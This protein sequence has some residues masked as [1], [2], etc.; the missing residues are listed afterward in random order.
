[1]PIEERWPRPSVMG[2]VNVTPD[3]FSD[4]GRFV[5]PGAAVA[6]AR[7]LTEEG[8]AI[9]DIGGESTRPGAAPV[10]AEDEL[11]RLGPVLEA[12]SGVS[13]SVDTS[14]AVVARRALELG[15]AMVND[16]T[17]LV[18]DPGM[19]E[20][21][22]EF[23]AYVCLMHM[24]GEPRTMQVAP[25]YDDVVDDVLE[26]LEQR[27]AF[28]V[29]RGIA[30]ERICVDPGFG[31]G[32][33]PDQNLELLRRLDELRSLGR[34]VLVGIS[35]KSTLG[36][37][38]GDRWCD[39]RL[40]VGVAGRCRGRVRARCLDGPGARRPRDSRGA[41]RRCRR[42][43]REGLRMR[44]EL[45]GLVV[46]GK[47]GYL[48]EER[49]LGQRFLVDLWVDVR[50]EATE[51]DRIEDTVDYRRLA[52]LVRE[53]FAGPE[54]L[55]LEGL[56]GAVADGIVERFPAVE[57]VRVRVRKPDVVLDPPVEFAAVVV[58]RPR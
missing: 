51:T 13:L 38:L 19:A 49:R 42:R 25:H 14:K 6:H 5:E 54:R 40:S 17:A 23:D 37:V 11:A 31:F 28:A 3:S 1:M 43:T 12:L 50:G 56:A 39:D 41:R 24:Q 27:I 2:V 55:L 48:E 4:G 45:A 57:R 47:H 44:I 18:G 32:K 9:V 35:R 46:F 36:K 53:V 7:R 33:T 10:S 30:E 15:A 58:E 8:A 34:P 22:A 26:F 20:V 29:E 16:V 21:V 52:A